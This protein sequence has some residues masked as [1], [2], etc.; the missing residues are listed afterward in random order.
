MSCYSY[1]VDECLRRFIDVKTTSPGFQSFMRRDERGG[2]F[3]TRY[4]NWNVSCTSCKVAI[5][6]HL[7]AAY[8]IGKGG[9]FSLILVTVD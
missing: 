6:R 4:S 2:S 9:V 7:D 3:P 1:C 8:T 5:R